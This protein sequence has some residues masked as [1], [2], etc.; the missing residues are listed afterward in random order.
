MLVHYQVLCSE[1]IHT[2]N[3]TQTGKVI[4]RNMCVYIHTCMHII[5]KKTEAMNLKESKEEYMEGFGGRNWKGK[6]CD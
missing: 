2:N 5:I 1:N 6:L 3:T 4:F